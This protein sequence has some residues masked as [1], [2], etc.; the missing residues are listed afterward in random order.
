MTS[1]QT[2]RRQIESGAARMSQRINFFK[3][4]IGVDNGAAGVAAV[5]Q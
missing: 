4:A 3:P 2:R 5:P 1:G